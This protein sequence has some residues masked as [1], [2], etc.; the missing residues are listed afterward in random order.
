M[1]LW[2][3]PFYVG[4]YL[5]AVHKELSLKCY[6][7]VKKPKVFFCILFIH[8]VLVIVWS[9][10]Y[11]IYSPVGT[12]ITVY[13]QDNLCI[14]FIALIYR[15]L[16]GVCGAITTILIL[17]LILRHI[18]CDLLTSCF[19]LISRYSLGIY[20]FSVYIVN[21]CLSHVPVDGQNYL[22][23][24]IESVSVLLLSLFAMRAIDGFPLLRKLLIGGR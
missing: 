17:K 5:I 11:Y 12:N 20:V 13:E 1:W 16:A 19:Y 15:I 9:C 2:L 21:P 8:L 3:Y 7:T 23:N 6:A 18:K 10:K 22:L 14:W 4:A 24:L